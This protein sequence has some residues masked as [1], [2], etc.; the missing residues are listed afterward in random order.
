VNSRQEPLRV[1]FCCSSVG[2]TNRG[3][4]SFFREAFDHLQTVPGLKTKLAKG[5]GISSEDEHV[6][7]CLPKTSSRAEFIGKITGRSSYAVEQWTSFFPIL[8]VIRRFDPQVI[9]SSDANLFFLLRR[10]R[11]LAGGNWT[12]LFSNGGPCRPPFVRM[13]AVH[14]IAPLHLEHAL[15]AGEHRSKHFMVPYGIHV[16]SGAPDMEPSA[17]RILR[18][19]LKLP[20]GRPIVLSVGWIAAQHKRMDHVVREV[21][22]VRRQRAGDGTSGPQLS[23]LNSQPYLVLLGSIDEQS[24]EILSL[25]REQLGEGNFTA[26]SVPYEEVADY[27]LAADVFTLASLHE[28]FGRVFLEALMHGLPVVAHDYAV[29]KFVLGEEGVIIDMNQP[30]ALAKALRGVLAQPNTP[31]AAARRRESVRARFSWP[32]L[33]PQYREMFRAAAA[34]QPRS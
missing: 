23:I 20:V 28:G 21:A 31:A 3:I 29:T 5:G 18:E 30:G 4:E 2:V 33:A 22:E 11:S 6:V 27:Y 17:Q 32:V 10:A 16:P 9:F 34:L 13:D 7:W 12:L 24:E 15:A 14:Q 8:R 26:R 1:L 19:K 25:A